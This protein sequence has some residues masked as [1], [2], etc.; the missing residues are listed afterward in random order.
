MAEIAG[1]ALGVVGV[2][3]LY[4]VT[5]QV[6]EQI[7][8][9]ASF[10]RDLE[11]QQAKLNAASASLRQWGAGTGFTPA[12]DLLPD[13]HAVFD[14]QRV[15]YDVQSALFCIRDACSQLRGCFDKTDQPGSGQNGS[16]SQSR[17]AA[18][19][20]ITAAGRRLRWAFQEKT[21]VED[22]LNQVICLVG[23]L[24]HIARPKDAASLESDAKLN[25]IL[26]TSQEQS[27]RIA[28]GLV[29][30]AKEL[31]LRKQEDIE[32][33]LGAPRTHLV[34]H[35][36]LSK[37][38]PGTCQWI[39]DHE[40]LQRW[41]TDQAVASSP[42]SA[43]CLWLYSRIPGAGKTIAASKLVESLK[44]ERTRS[45][46]Y[47]FG[48]HESSTNHGF[49]GIVRS[50]IHQLIRCHGW[51]AVEAAYDDSR[52]DD[53]P[54]DPWVILRSI[55]TKSASTYLVLDGLDEVEDRTGKYASGVRAEFLR[56]LLASI[57]GTTTR[58]V[59]VSRY[60]RDIDEVVSACN[61]GEERVS[62]V[63]SEIKLQQTAVDLERVA[64]YGVSSMFP[65]WTAEQ[66]N[67]VVAALVKRADGMFVLLN[68]ILRQLQTRSTYS[69]VLYAMSQPLS[70]HS[71]TD[72][73]QQAY[74][75]QVVKILSSPPAVRDLCLGVL[76][77]VQQSSR[78]LKIGELLDVLQVL[79]RR[80]VNAFDIPKIR[81]LHDLDLCLL[82]HCP[83]FLSLRSDAERFQHRTLHLSHY[84]VKEFLQC[85]G[86]L[87]HS[88]FKHWKLFSGGPSANAYLAKACLAYLLQTEFAKYPAQPISGAATGVFEYR[89]DFGDS[90]KRNHPF[91]DYAA[92]FWWRH[93]DLSCSRPELVAFLESG[94]T[95]VKKRSN[96]MTTTAMETLRQAEQLLE[97]ISP[98]ETKGYEKFMPLDNELQ[99]LCLEF[100]GLKG[101]GACCN[102]KIWRHYYL[103]IWKTADD[104]YLS[105]A[106]DQ[107][108][109]PL[110]MFGPEWTTRPIW[111]TLDIYLWQ[112]HL[113]TTYRDLRKLRLQSRLLE[114]MCMH[115]TALT[116][117]LADEGADINFVWPDHRQTLSMYTS[118]VGISSSPLFFHIFQTHFGASTEL[119]KPVM[120][121]HIPING[122]VFRAGGG[123]WAS[124]RVLWGFLFG[125]VLQRRVYDAWRFDDPGPYAMSDLDTIRAMIN[126]HIEANNRSL[127]FPSAVQAAVLNT[128]AM[129]ANKVE[130]L[131]VL[132]ANG[133]DANVGPWL[134]PVA[135][136]VG[137]SSSVRE[138]LW[139][140]LPQLLPS[141]GVS[142][143]RTF[144]S[145]LRLVEHDTDEYHR[146]D[147]V[148][149]LIGKQALS[150]NSAG[151]V[152]Q[153]KL[154]LA[155]RRN[156]EEEVKRLL[157]SGVNVN[158]C[159]PW[160]GSALY[161][162][163]Y[164]GKKHMVELLLDRD[165]DPNLAV[166][167]SIVPL[168]LE[169]DFEWAGLWRKR[170]AKDGI[171]Y[172][173]LQAAA[174]KGHQDI[175][176]LL[177]HRGAEVNRT[178]GTSGGSALYFAVLA[179]KPRYLAAEW[180]QERNEGAKLQY[181]R[182]LNN[183]DRDK[184]LA[185]IRLLVDNGADVNQPG[186][187][188]GTPLQAACVVGEAQAVLYLLNRKADPNVTGGEWGTALQAALVHHPD[189]DVEAVEKGGVYDPEDPPAPV[190]L[191]IRL[192]AVCLLVA[193]V[194]EFRDLAWLAGRG[195]PDDRGL[196][197]AYALLEYGADPTLVA[198]PWGSAIHAAAYWSS[199]P[200]L[201]VVLDAKYSTPT[202][203]R[204]AANVNG[205]R[206]GRAINGPVVA[207][208]WD[209]VALLLRGAGAGYSYVPLLRFRARKVALSAFDR[210]CWVLG[211]AW[212]IRDVLVFS[213][214]VAVAS[215]ACVW[216]KMAWDELD[217]KAREWDPRLGGL[218]MLVSLLGA[219]YVTNLR[220]N[221]AEDT[222]W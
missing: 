38:L 6:F 216:V 114:A 213:L 55:L 124:P 147:L 181:W 78:P 112:N 3:G 159:G 72:M 81:N 8:D 151:W 49:N 215:T 41:W 69:D 26:L 125:N 208:R 12:G 211:C 1:L 178:D 58:L 180:S 68:A 175:V 104:D 196:L 79:S 65:T 205:G 7:S 139:E 167:T 18:R 201:R 71:N 67:D 46:A 87:E 70:G 25:E 36:A 52:D 14:D 200:A 204:A 115:S 131:N 48:T 135:T 73:L 82:R 185:L 203:R 19:K 40:L 102:Y 96:D 207:G 127:F 191:G 122:T 141:N 76:L 111:R 192:Y 149:A 75:T 88:Q 63:Q 187:R 218:W 20:K 85:T 162:A 84:S 17:T 177:L 171:T 33:W 105:R 121:V 53:R 221:W 190:P 189:P 107:L 103:G 198:G 142:Q 119:N 74:Q 42:D 61:T 59:I 172:S 130:M 165:A 2:A 15:L 170:L 83:L 99:G 50:W 176:K 95:A 128:Q 4:S 212:A 182:D 173:P 5:L 217:R 157:D 174:S 22:L 11:T 29:K 144:A 136:F 113:F 148:S 47:Y 120:P 10:N 134:R 179:S 116:A 183:K 210:L 152:K 140:M 209:K 133:A 89:E 132:F 98:K 163:C 106:R 62:V 90:L 222:L 91:Y 51:E 206:M 145:L 166:E 97:V 155:V 44:R 45:T 193:R 150:C 143:G 164:T 21:K 109:F 16:G 161:V 154:Q 100:L 80:D 138:T 168:E 23:L 77:W 43:Q 160:Y 93:L 137:D 202:A 64:Q 220:Q 186:G 108:A 9:I 146:D 54:M 129:T 60:E 219:G 94:A 214:V 158:R 194:F 118:Y 32:T 92:F 86:F 24:Y 37:A 156:D 66:R 28:D 197:L 101:D 57:R 184:S 153:E 13:H 30:Q 169:W 35:T 188:Y 199:W 126:F 117:I 56:T 39:I 31:Q 110:R 123:G 34:Y 27:W 195:A